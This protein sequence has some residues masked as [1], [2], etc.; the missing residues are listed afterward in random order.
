[1]F[2]LIYHD[3]QDNEIFAQYGEK[4]VREDY[5]KVENN[6][7]C[8]A[9]GVTR[10]YIDATPAKYPKNK[11]EVKEWVEKYP[12]PSGAYK[13]AKIIADNFVK[14]MKNEKHI[15]E[16]KILA[17][18]EKINEDVWEINKDRKIDYLKED[19]YCAVAVGGIIQ[20]NILY[21]FSVGDCHITLL[22]DECNIVFTTI[23]NHKPFEDYI[24]KMYSKENE[25]NWEEKET[26]I[27]VR[28]DFRNKPE[29][30]NSFGVISGE[31]EA[32]KFIETYKI[33]LDKVKYICAYSDGCEPDFASKKAIKEIIQNTREKVKEGKEKTLIIYENIIENGSLQ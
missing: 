15:S 20:E 29:E 6:I 10:D 12:Y 31:E 24:E 7:F 25:Y 21:A 28:R 18:I 16:A 4:T 26:R 2:K 3:T 14:Y 5:Y 11:D 27:M 8:V 30:K 22:D 13:A 33:E 23:N 9:D 17:I 19:Y 32:L 1:M